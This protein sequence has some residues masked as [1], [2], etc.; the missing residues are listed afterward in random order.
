MDQKNTRPFNL[1]H[2][3]AGAPFALATGEGV[4][5]VKWD[6]KHAQ[7]L[8]TVSKQDAAVRTYRADGTQGH[9]DGKFD[10]VMTPLG[11]IDGKPV[12]VGDEVETAGHRVRVQPGDHGFTSC[13]WPVPEKQYPVTRLTGVELGRIYD[14]DDTARADWTNRGMDCLTDVANAALRHAVDSG[15]LLIPTTEQAYEIG[16]QAAVEAFAGDDPAEAAFWRFDACK[17]GYNKKWKGRPQSERDAFKAEYRAALADRAAY[18]MAVAEAVRREC[19]KELAEKQF[20]F[21]VL[22]VD[23][24]AIIAKVSSAA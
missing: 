10:L 13:R 3:K 6:R 2:A 7:C 1:E 11:Y 17:R 20:T 22:N 23:L 21:P 5:I 16:R 15:Q 4:E 18:G 24:A 14:G 19:E 9:G 8:V 12:F